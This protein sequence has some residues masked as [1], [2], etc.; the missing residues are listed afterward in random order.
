MVSSVTHVLDSVGALTECLFLA[1]LRE[2]ATTCSFLWSMFQAWEKRASLEPGS[3]PSM[4]LWASVKFRIIC[5]VLALK[6]FGGYHECHECGARS[7]ALAVLSESIV[8][9]MMSFTRVKW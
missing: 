7:G 1:Q 3:V 2:H 4:F 6:G 8:D 9:I 5:S